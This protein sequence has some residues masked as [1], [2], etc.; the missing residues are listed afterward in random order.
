MPQT[1]SASA[2]TGET[3]PFFAAKVVMGINP[4]RAFASA[5]TKCHPVRGVLAEIFPGHARDFTGAVNLEF[6]QLV[7]PHARADR[8]RGQNHGA[9]RVDNRAIG[10]RRPSLGFGLND[11]L[12]RDDC[13][14]ALR[15]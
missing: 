8:R 12:D 10:Q 6:F 9:I 4:A 11:E 3:E 15:P 13:L 7:R 14:D 2:G 1:S 5:R